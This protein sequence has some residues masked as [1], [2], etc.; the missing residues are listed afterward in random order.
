MGVNHVRC[1]FY[2]ILKLM[3]DIVH[4]EGPVI[5][6]ARDGEVY[7]CACPTP[8]VDVGPVR[9]SLPRLEILEVHTDGGRLDLDF[10]LDT[11]QTRTE[12]TS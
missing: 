3:N 7:G 6:R 1:H 9:V 8:C 5:V 2:G 12:D 11:L 4:T 10:I